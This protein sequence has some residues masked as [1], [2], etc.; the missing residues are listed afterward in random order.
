MAQ[1]AN[2]PELQEILTNNLGFTSLAGEVKVQL[3]IQW[4]PDNLPP[5]SSSLL[6]IASSKGI[7]AA[8]GPESLVLV[9]TDGLRA[10][11]KNSKKKD[12]V[13]QLQPD[14]VIPGPR[15]SHVAFTSDNTCLIVAA[16]SGGGLAAHAVEG[17]LQKHTVPIF[18]LSTEGVA[19]KALAPNPDPAAAH[20]VLVL[21]ANGHLMLANFQEKIFVRGPNG[22]SI[23][24]NVTSVAWSVRGKQLVAGLADGTAVQLDPQGTIKAMIPRPPG[25]GDGIQ[26]K[27]SFEL[28]A[29]TLTNFIVS[30]IVWL[31]NDEFLTVHSASSPPADSPPEA[32]FHWIRSDKGRTQFEFRKAPAEPCFPLQN[33][34]PAAYFISRIRKWSQLEDTVILTSAASPDVGLMTNSQIPLNKQ[35][36]NITNVYTITTL[37]NEARKA[38]LPMSLANGMDDTFP[39]GQAVDYSSKDK[40]WQPIPGDDVVT[41]E[42]KHPLPAFALLN[43]EGVLLYWWFV[44]DEALRRPENEQVPC[45]GIGVSSKSPETS[46]QTQVRSPASTPVPASKPAFGSSGF[47]NPQTPSFGT[48][49]LAKPAQPAFGQSAFGQPGLGQPSFGKPAFG[50]TPALGSA[51]PW[52]TPAAA[53]PPVPAFGKPAFGSASTPSGTGFGQIASLGTGT[54]SPWGTP[55]PTASMVP[56]K[57]AFGGDSA[58][59]S[60]FAKLATNPAASPFSSMVASKPN[61][62]SSPFAPMGGAKPSPFGAVPIKTEPSFGQTPQQSFG[63]TVTISS[64]NGGSTIGNQSLFGSNTFGTPTQPSN[65]FSQTSS[66]KTE[67]PEKKNDQNMSDDTPANQSTPASS[68]TPK[69]SLFGL[70]TPF[71]I[72]SSFKPGE[73]AKEKGDDEPESKGSMGGFGLGSLGAGLGSA[74]P[75]VKPDPTLPTKSLFDIPP[76]PVVKDKAP[77][78][79][80]E[81]QQPE[82]PEVQSKPAP[83]SS[84]GAYSAD[85]SAI[86]KTTEDD[87]NIPSSPPGTEDEGIEDDDDDDDD[88]DED[89][90]DSNELSSEQQ[91]DAVATPPRGDSQL[92]SSPPTG[93]PEFSPPMPSTTPF[94]NTPF[95]PKS[96]FGVKGP[97]FTKSPLSESTGIPP[98]APTPPVTGP[99]RLFPTLRSTTTPS[100]LPQAPLF[101]PTK[102]Q[103]SPRSPS[104]TRRPIPIPSQPVQVTVVPQPPLTSR[105]GYAKPPPAQI[106][107][108]KSNLLSDLCDDEDDAIRAN[109]S[110]PLEPT[111]EIPPFIAHT[112]YAGLVKL[113]GVPASIERVYRDINSMIDTLGQ[114]ARALA[115]FVAGHQEG[116]DADADGTDIYDTSLKWTLDDID[117]LK[118][119][120]HNL[121][122]AILQDPIKNT[123]DLRT[124]I[125]EIKRKLR[126]TKEDQKKMKAFLQAYKDPAA[127][128]KRRNA[129]LD[130]DAAAHQRELLTQL[131]IFKKAL[132]EAEDKATLV[133]AKLAARGAAKQAPT[134]EAVEKTI[135]KM[136][137]MVQQRSGEVD[138]LET[139]MRKLGIVSGGSRPGSTRNSPA[140]GRSFGLAST[141]EE[142]TEEADEEEEEWRIE[143]T[144]DV[145]A[146]RRAILNRIREEFDKRDMSSY[147]KVPAGF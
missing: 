95:A 103:E 2:G 8:A 23:K 70:K 60:G 138:Y 114:N 88:V 69:P 135:R 66:F 111:L 127:Q 53:K 68:V 24:D 45:P 39:I 86:V 76:R 112:D 136:T 48:P 62:I 32:V 71:A 29:H 117:R 4:A 140:K 115:S 59:T 67:V 139:Q 34:T 106:H 57:S 20:L 79:V 15:L 16:E 113:E 61:T 137:A 25:L 43:N 75:E 97:M 40:V 1:I 46:A 143:R 3:P 9:S 22:A 120:E 77:P 130:P 144:V 119:L 110:K 21:L 128:S 55:A 26:S 56:Q 109:L 5:T 73:T 41:E 129:P 125:V 35:D 27:L 108:A 72:G 145:R 38:A 123:N 51:S 17:L 134:V 10:A 36:S 78:K 122:R 126:P 84:S 44:N 14:L 19:V 30:S 124:D 85:S 11:F 82:P 147:Q 50:A 49:S 107:S 141:H 99:S 37:E 65:T 90:G 118:S 87:D 81:E 93:E 131:A 52:G 96:M 58:T 54:S 18:E 13:V 31:A 104:P 105:A 63:S 89:D 102:Q 80:K 28:F 92:T 142:N 98:P 116:F 101:A 12:E 121:E 7:L 91:S 133:K 47:G 6:S 42:G 83:S 100:G 33:R 146:K 132:A 74:T 94:G 64:A